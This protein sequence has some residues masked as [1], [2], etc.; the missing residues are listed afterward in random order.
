MS[1]PLRV[2]L[3]I[4]GALLLVIGLTF[5]LKGKEIR[6]LFAVNNLFK[7]ENIVHNFSHMPELFFHEELDRGNHPISELPRDPQTLPNL[8]EWAEERALTAI[9]V[10]HDGSLVFE[11]YYQNTN[12]TD[13][14][15]SWSVAKSFLS[16]LTGILLDEGA[17]DSI[18][19]PVTKYVPSLVGSAYDGAT[20]KDALQMSTGVEFNEDYL[21]PKSDINRMGRALALGKSMDRF[22][23]ALRKKRDPPGQHWHYVSIDTH[24]VGMVIRGATGQRV[25]DLMAEKIIQPLAPEQAPIYIT[26]KLGV[27]FVLGGLN[28]RTRDY[29]RFGQMFL[30]NGNYQNQQIV[31][32]AWVKESTRPSANT[33]DDEPGYGYFWWTPDKTSNGEYFA[34]GIYGQY[35]YINENTNTVIAI[36]SADRKFRDPGAHEQNL[37]MF[38]A[39]STTLHENAEHADHDAEHADVDTKNDRNAPAPEDAAPDHEDDAHLDAAE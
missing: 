27:A 3:F 35:V 34:R 17:I 11:D 1:R 2:L 31:P 32:A 19:D 30:Q 8:D 4:A 23:D 28:L 9:V 24:V 10:L 26:D 38:R 37:E 29:A 16:A 12:D 20:L 6:R 5:L 15:I 21:D 25:S 18:D 7:E 22:A 36:N 14:R 33:E 13:L 39:I